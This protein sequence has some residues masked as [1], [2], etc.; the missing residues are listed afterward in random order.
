MPEANRVTY[1]MHHHVFVFTTES[2]GQGSL[3][4]NATDI[5]PAAEG[6]NCSDQALPLP[7]HLRAA[8]L[9]AACVRLERRVC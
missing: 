6:R 9:K 2:N 3:S 5:A 1:L 7:F 8:R 4:T